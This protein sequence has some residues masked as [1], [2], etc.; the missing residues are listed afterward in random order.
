M[1]DK[2]SA[3]VVAIIVIVLI[4]FVVILIY[5]DKKPETFNVENSQNIV[6]DPNEGISNWINHIYEEANKVEENTI[7]NE[8]V[9]ENEV[10][11][12]PTTD[13]SSEVITEPILNREEKVKQL[14]EQ[15]WG[16]LEGFYLDIDL[17]GDGRY[18]VIVRDENT[19][20]RG[21]Y[22]VDVDKEKI[23]EQ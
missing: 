8:A 7:E 21:K 1:K 20:D 16:D 18:R 11:E 2:G 23:T 19:A 15:E 4:A 5:D 22:I 13:E 10:I 17:M 6:K 12:P 3:L 9:E 14:V